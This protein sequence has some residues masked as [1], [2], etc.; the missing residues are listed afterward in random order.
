MADMIGAVEQ[1]GR[2]KSYY[3]ILSY[4]MGFLLSFILLWLSPKI[5][6]NTVWNWLVQS[7]GSYGTMFLVILASGI[8]MG[9]VSFKAKS[10]MVLCFALGFV[11]CPVF[12]VI[13]GSLLPPIG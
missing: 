2:S 7:T 5:F 6:G 13:I 11:M 8:A 1:K 10:Y 9:Y 4:G 12:L 3:Y